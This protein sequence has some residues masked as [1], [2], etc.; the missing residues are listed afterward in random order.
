[1]SELE[2]IDVGRVERIHALRGMFGATGPSTA[3]LAAL[4]AQLDAVRMPAGTIVQQVGGPGSII[5]FVLEGELVVEREGKPFGVFGARSVVGVLPAFAR[6]PQTFVT[7]VTKDA[8]ALRLRFDDMM[9]VFEDHFDMLQ[10]ALSGM[11]RNTIE[12]RRLI[13]PHAG[14]EA[15]QR[16]DPEEPA[17]EPL[18]LIERMLVLRSSLAVHTHIDELAELARA[19]QEVHFPRGGVLWDENN[20]A[21]HMLILVCGR[22]SC[23]TSDGLFFKF[24]PGDLVGALDTI[25]GTPRWFTAH[26]DSRVMALAVER[27]ALLDL[28]EDQ[29]ELGFDILRMLA[30]VLTMLRERV[31]APPSAAPQP[32]P[33]TAAHT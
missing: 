1:M 26:A 14:Y 30:Q 19:A 31:V 12:L 21:T 13:R 2:P 20:D 8:V 22:V 10:S 32:R 27:D 4:A 29:A 28:V 25:S 17:T 6:D 3:S 23:H 24:G 15:A 16:P 5:Y 11:S 7:T 33:A 18:G 9:E